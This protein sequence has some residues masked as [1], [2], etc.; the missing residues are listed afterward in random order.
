MT[1]PAN[2]PDLP[3]RYEQRRQAEAK[4]KAEQ[5]AEPGAAGATN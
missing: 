4:Q 5:T 2:I 1:L 3:D